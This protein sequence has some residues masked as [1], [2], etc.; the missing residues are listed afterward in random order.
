MNKNTKIVLGVIVGVVVI[1]GAYFSPRSTHTT[2]IQAGAVGDVNSSSRIA[3]C[4]LDM[5]T[6][7][8]T[9]ATTTGA[10][11]CLLNTDSRDRIITSV[12][13]YGANLGTM[14][15]GTLGVQAT[16]TIVVSTSTTPFYPNSGNSILSQ[17]IATTT[18]GSTAL[19]AVFFATSS[20]GIIGTGSTVTYGAPVINSFARVWAAGTYLSA[21]MN[22]TST[23][24]SGTLTIKYVVAP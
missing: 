15:N 9:L 23:T 7:S 19:P 17:G 14:V 21:Y 20:P 24:G 11:G 2:V 4:S 10:T 5:S 1:I 12:E 8:P 6:T 3:Q 13:F 16:T 22:A 18:N